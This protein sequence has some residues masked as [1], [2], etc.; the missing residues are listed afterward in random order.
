MKSSSLF[1][2]KNA[3]LKQHQPIVGGTNLRR[4]LLMRQTS[5]QNLFFYHNKEE[6]RPKEDLKLP[7]YKAKDYRTSKLPS[8]AQLLSDDNLQKKKA[9]TYSMKNITQMHTQKI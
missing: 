7:L 5:T 6:I 2:T 9:R 3:S 4:G 1:V 8:L